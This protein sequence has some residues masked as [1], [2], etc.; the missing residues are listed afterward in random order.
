LSPAAIRVIAIGDQKGNEMA[1]G[2]HRSR[3]DRDQIA[4]N[5]LHLQMSLFIFF[6]I[7]I[8]FHDPQSMKNV[9]RMQKN[10]KKYF[11]SVLVM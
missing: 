11:F 9:K 7:F 10:V 3:S 6:L 1:I 5:P 2:D 4:I 8:F